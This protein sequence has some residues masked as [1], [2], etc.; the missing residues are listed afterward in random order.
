[1]KQRK[2]L[3]RTPLTRK[4]PMPRGGKQAKRPPMVKARRQSVTPEERAGK[5]KVKRR[6]GGTCEIWMCG[7]APATDW[8][9]RVR[10]SQGGSWSPVNGLHA[11]RFCHSIITHDEKVGLPK[12]WCLKSYQDP[13]TTPVYRRGE[14]VLLDTEGG[15]ESVNPEAIGGDA[16]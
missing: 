11:C 7:G 16:A 6:S 14:W 13:A 8:S 1:M 4:T 10:R 12:G 15:W 2:P 5:D 3:R 9:H